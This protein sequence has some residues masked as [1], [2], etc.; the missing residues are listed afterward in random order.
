MPSPIRRLDALMWP[1]TQE[2]RIWS[3]VSPTSSSPPLVTVKVEANW[4]F[5]P[6]GQITGCPLC[7]S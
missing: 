1:T 7:A 3:P 4:E 2:A 6:S 5:T